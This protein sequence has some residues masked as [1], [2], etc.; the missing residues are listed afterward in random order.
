MKVVYDAPSHS[1]MYY[2]NPPFACFISISY[3]VRGDPLSNGAT[4]SIKSLF[5]IT[6]VVGLAG[7]KGTHAQRDSK[8]AESVLVPKEFVDVTTK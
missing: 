4:Q 5:P 7:L 1:V 6:L 8:T 3:L 2:E